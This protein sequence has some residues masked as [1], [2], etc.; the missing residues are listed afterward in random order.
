M[1]FKS[2]SQV[3]EYY[4]DPATAEVSSVRHDNV[5]VDGGKKDSWLDTW[6]SIGRYVDTVGDEAKTII[7]HA[8][9]HNRSDAD[10]AKIMRTFPA[11]V[12]SQRLKAVRKLDSDFRDAEIIGGR[13]I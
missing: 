6:A 12:E 3:L 11:N 13:I 5:R 2:V 4:F 10:I 1:V 8:Y 9:G 7:A